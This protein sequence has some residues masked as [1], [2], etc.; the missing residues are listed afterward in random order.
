MSGIHRI[1]SADLIHSQVTLGLIVVK[2]RLLM[3][4][5]AQDFLL[6]CFESQE[7]VD[8]FALS[9]FSAGAILF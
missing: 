8:G 9:C 4:H 6:F 1:L 5:K 3:R 2:A 7:Q